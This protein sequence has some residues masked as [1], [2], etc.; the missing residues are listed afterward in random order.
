MAHKV[1]ATVE[2][3]DK[4]TGSIAGAEGEGERARDKSNN[5][6]LSVLRALALRCASQMPAW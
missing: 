3:D 1:A 2:E 4:T 5:R 6:C